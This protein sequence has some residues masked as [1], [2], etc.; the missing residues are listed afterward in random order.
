MIRHY[1]R[2]TYYNEAVKFDTHSLGCT[3]MWVQPTE[4][5]TK[6]IAA[7]TIYT[8]FIIEV[9]DHYKAIDNAGSF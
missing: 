7:D 9:E 8:T 3:T 6:T 5:K 1:N 2:R 4:T